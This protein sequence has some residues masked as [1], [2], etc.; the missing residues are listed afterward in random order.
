L[1]NGCPFLFGAIGASSSSPL[2]FQ[3]DLRWVH[4]IL[5][6]IVQIFHPPFEQLSNKRVNRLQKNILENVHDLIS[7]IISKLSS[8]CHRIQLKFCA[9]PSLGVW[10][11]VYLIIP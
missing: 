5:L 10:L 7:N 8:N 2:P 4:D 9:S 1:Q 11:F 6:S 3:V